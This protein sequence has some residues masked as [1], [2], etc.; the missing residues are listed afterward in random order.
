LLGGAVAAL[1]PLGATAATAPA[2]TTMSPFK[3]EAE[4][5]PDGLRIQPSQAVLNA[6]LLEQH[7]V[8][9]FQDATGLAPNLFL[10]HSDSRG[11]GDILALRGVTN[12]L[13]FSAP[14]VGLYVDDVPGGSVSS[15]PSSLLNIDTVVV[16]AGPQSTEY[17]RNAPG[18]MIEI[19]TRQPGAAHQGKVQAEYGSYNLTAFQAAFQGPLSSNAGYSVAFGYSDREGYIDNTFLGGTVDDRRS[20]AGRAALTWK[21]TS[22]LQLR[23]GL[24]SETFDD[25]GQRL[26]SLF[27]PLTGARNP[28]PFKVSSDL[29]GETQID[30]LQLHFQARKKL[31]FGTLIAT[32]A[33]QEFD[34]DP[35]TTDLD[36]S[37]FPGA[38]SRVLQNEEIW[39]QEFR[40]ESA[41]DATKAAWRA[42]VFLAE[43]D[44]DGDATRQFGVPPQPP[45]VPPGFIQNERTTFE[46]EQKTVAAFASL[47]HPVSN[48]L[49][50]KFG[51][52]YEHVDSE[53]DRSKRATNNFNFPTPQDPRLLRGDKDEYLSASAGL[54]YAVNPALTLHARTAL[55]HKP[56]GF[57]GFT[58]TPALVGFDSEEQWANEIGIT[59]GPRQGRFGGSV[60]GFWNQID[61][62]QFERTVPNSTDFVVVNAREVRSRGL[63]AKFMFSPIERVWWDFHAGYTEATFENH[64]DSTGASVNGRRV[65][66]VPRSTLRTG[67]TVELAQGL[68]ANASYAHVGRTYY[69]ERNTG[70]FAQGNYNVVNAQLRYRFDRYAVTVYGHNL[71]E[72]DYYQFINPE[73]AA[74]SP[75]APR[76]FGVQVAY[77]F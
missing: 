49:V 43:S 21:P 64:R 31:D 69:D 57:S 37:Q 56:A 60:L 17:G 58:G 70:T 48:D 12:S 7:G 1:A 26:S 15:Y 76:R 13:F 16:R 22:D 36:L 52:R 61:D 66:F 51:G 38:S 11:F 75:G 28:D 33:R 29:R 55:A 20:L 8:A 34:L 67:V 3:V 40:L 77:E 41:P 74:G 44:I 62:Y 50:L 45:F 73:I 24:L 68:T 10:S 47:D 2:P 59:F 32:T 65:P 27:N 23:F 19:R 71:F 5:G 53:I 25:G 6:T 63:E 46:T 54:S 9:Q 39:S 72:E 14:G 18:G 35:S 30:R 4:T 42:G